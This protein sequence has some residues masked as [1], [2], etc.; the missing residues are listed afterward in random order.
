[1][2]SSKWVDV[3]E[4]CGSEH[5][6]GEKDEE[7][8]RQGE[9]RGKARGNRSVQDAIT[10]SLLLLKGSRDKKLIAYPN[11]MTTKHMTQTRMSF[12]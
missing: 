12:V 8:V 6:K 4:G 11:T 7:G 2:P 3:K 1:M 5:L 10:A 9:I